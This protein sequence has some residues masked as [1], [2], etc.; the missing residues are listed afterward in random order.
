MCLR[1]HKYVYIYTIHTCV[2]PYP[3]DKKPSSFVQS[4]EISHCQV[5][6]SRPCDSL[7][8]AVH[9]QQIKR[10]RAADLTY[11]TISRYRQKDALSWEDSD[12][13][14]ESVFVFRFVQPDFA[15]PFFLFREGQEWLV[16]ARAGHPRAS[17]SHPPAQPLGCHA[18]RPT[19]HATRQPPSAHS[20][21][22][23]CP[24]ATCANQ[25]VPSWP[26]TPHLGQQA[27][28]PLGR[29]H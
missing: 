1:P 27:A 5:F 17:A 22:P 21:V 25:Q 4:S 8:S 28:R 3:M 15:H 2:T 13:L 14:I 9:N 29:S 20:Q 18:P 16:P 26:L 11:H 24:R 6:V 10:F 7:D 19:A 12:A 23:P